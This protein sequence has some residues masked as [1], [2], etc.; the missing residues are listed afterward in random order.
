MYGFIVRGDRV[1]QPGEISKYELS[2]AMRAKAEYE[3]LACLTEEMV[4][5][6][7]NPYVTDEQGNWLSREQLISRT[8]SGWPESLLEKGWEPEKVAAMV[9]IIE[10]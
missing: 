1:E 4:L 6:G 5:P 3:S 10:R 8:R 7:S 9:R 2:I